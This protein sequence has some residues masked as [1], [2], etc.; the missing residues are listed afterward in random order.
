VLG[1][2]GHDLEL[3]AAECAVELDLAARSVA[4]QIAA[5]SVR[6]VDA[7]ER[8]RRKPGALSADDKRKVD[9]Q[10]AEEVLHA[11]R[12]PSI[13]FRSTHVDATPN[14]YRVRGRISLH[15]VE[16][17]IAFDAERRGDRIEA[18]IT[19]HQPDFGIA[20]FKAFAGALRVHADV[21]VRVSLEPVEQA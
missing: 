15:G 14:G 5:R 1:V 6:V 12:F 21:I 8:G 19:L 10:V 2:V 18:E 7:V 4:V 17:E 16:R 3:V 13:A 11:G 9:R 20:P